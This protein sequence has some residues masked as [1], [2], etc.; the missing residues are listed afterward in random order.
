MEVR[1]GSQNFKVVETDKHVFGEWDWHTGTISLNKRLKGQDWGLTLLHEVIHVIS[2]LQGLELSE[3]QTRALEQGLGGFFRDNP[4][5]A[6]KI[7]L[8]LIK[9]EE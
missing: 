3:S 5:I 6:R 4:Q 1:V 8:S 7:S 9:V 2:D